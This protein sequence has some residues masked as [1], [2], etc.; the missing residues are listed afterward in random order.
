M[1]I[2]QEA[3][4]KAQGEYFEKKT[5]KVNEERVN[6]EEVVNS[7]VG[8][9]APQRIKRPTTMRLPALVSILTILLVIYGFKLS[10]QYSRPHEKEIGAP[11][12][13]SAPA[14]KTAHSFIPSKIGPTSFIP[15]HLSNFVLSGVMYVENKPQAIINGHVLEEGDKI[16]GAT[17]LV[18]EK[19]FVLLD[20]NDA[21]VRLEMKKQ[22]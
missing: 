9:Q 19:D 6:E 4:K 1:S 22:Y 8:I 15:M 20:V 12:P 3:L 10:L 13:A 7:K 14:S 16:S 21:N 2:I 18:I 11:S 5:P 17:V